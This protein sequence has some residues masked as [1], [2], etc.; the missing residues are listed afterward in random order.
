MFD[1][2][3]KK[4]VGSMRYPSCDGFSSTLRRAAHTQI[5]NEDG[6]VSL[7]AV[8]ELWEPG[9]VVLLVVQP[10]DQLGSSAAFTSHWFADE[11]RSNCSLPSD[12]VRRSR[13]SSVTCALSFCS[14]SDW[15]RIRIAH[16]ALQASD[17]SLLLESG[18]T[19][20][21]SLPSLGRL[22]D[23]GRGSAVARQR[24]R[25]SAEQWCC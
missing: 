11:A 22:R 3:S 5:R 19:A 18:I 7:F 10:N 13:C 9:A 24:P 12:A 15:G 4:M 21:S 14:P 17:D 23:C 2:T 20:T 16:K 1:G 8:T 6:S 25:L